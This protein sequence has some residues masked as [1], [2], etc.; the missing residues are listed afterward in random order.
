MN[1]K[2]TLRSLGL[3]FI[4]ISA[5]TI[6]YGQSDVPINS[7]GINTWF[8]HYYGP[9]GFPVNIWQTIS[10]SQPKLAR[11]GG[12]G[13]DNSPLNATDLQALV[14]EIRNN[15]GA[16]P[17]I[18]IPVGFVVTATPPYFRTVA[19]TAAQAAALVSAINGP[20]GTK[21]GRVNL[22]SIG[23]ESDKYFTGTTV[24]FAD[25][26]QFIR[27]F[28]VNFAVEMKKIDPNIKIFAPDFSWWNRDQPIMKLLIGDP[29]ATPTPLPATAGLTICEKALFYD[30]AF[31]AYPNIGLIDGIDFHNYPFPCYDPSCNALHPDATYDE[32]VNYPIGLNPGNYSPA[33]G[34]DV[35]VSDIKEFI[36]YAN[37]NASRTT[38]TNKLQWAVTEMNLEDKNPAIGNPGNASF[39]AGQ[40]WA[41][42]FA[43]ML[44][45]TS[46]KPGAS[47]IIPWTAKEGASSDHGY[48]D[49]TGNP[50]STFFHM[51]F[52][53][54][55]MKSGSGYTNQLY[56]AVIKGTATNFPNSTYPYI[57]TFG[58]K[59]VGKNQAAIMII[60][61]SKT[62][63]YTYEVGLNGVSSPWTT[64]NSPSIQFNMGLNKS[65][66]GTIG[67]ETTRLLVFDCSGNYEGMWEY[68]STDIAPKWIDNPGILSTIP[69]TILPDPSTISPIAGN[70]YNF[71]FSGAQNY[72]WF[73]IAGLTVN[74]PPKD[75]SDV[76]LL[77]NPGSTDY[78]FTM[79]DGMGCISTQLVR[80]NNTG[81]V[82]VTATGSNNYYPY[83]AIITNVRKACSGQNNGSITLQVFGAGTHNSIIT[84]SNGFTET[85]LN[86]TSTI[87]N[88]APGTY[89]VT[90]TT[91][92]E[93]TKSL[94]AIVETDIISIPIVNVSNICSST[95][96]T[97]NIF[98]SY[99]WLKNG[100]PLAGA[101]NY[102]LITNQL[103]SYQVAVTTVNGCVATSPSF[104]T[105]AGYTFPN[106]TAINSIVTF[107]SNETINNVLRIQNSGQLTINNTTVQFGSLGKIII[108][109]GGTL[110][111]NSSI[112]KYYQA[113]CSNWQGIDVQS[114]GTLNL[115]NSAVNINGPYKLLILAG[116]TLNY[117]QGSSVVLADNTS[118]MEIQGQLNI[119]ANANFTYSG[120]GFVRFNSPLATNNISA[121]TGSSMVFQ[122][123]NNNQ[124]AL[125]VNQAVLFIPS[126]IAL[127]KVNKCQVQLGSNAM[128]MPQGLN[129]NIVFTNSKLSGNA[130]SGGLIIFGQPNVTINNSIFDSGSY[131]I[132]A[133]LTYGGA[134]LTISNC[135]FQ[136]C[137]TGLLTHDKGVTLKSV[138][139]YDCNTGWVAEA[140]SF[141]CVSNN[142]I[143]GSKTR[144]NVVGIQYRGGANGTLFLNNSKVNGNYTDGIQMEG[145]ELKV[146][147]GEIKDNTDNGIYLS[148]NATLNMSNDLG[149]GNV[150]ATNNGAQNSGSY[151][152][153]MNNAKNIWL[154]N[155]FNDFTRGT[156]NF[157]CN[158][159][160][161]Q[162]PMIIY[163]TT[164]IEYDPCGNTDCSPITIT[165][166]RNKWVNLNGNVAP[167]N[168]EEYEI[169]TSYNCGL[170]GGGVPRNVLLTDA[171]P[172][173]LVKCDNNPKQQKSISLLENCPTCPTINTVNFP[174]KKLDKA[175]TSVIAIMDS[176]SPG[177][178]KKAEELFYEILKYPIPSPNKDTKTLLEISYQLMLESLGQAF[179]KSELISTANT[180]VLTSN[181]QQMVEI[182]DIRII[183]YICLEDYKQRLAASMDKAQAYRLAERRDI[184]L[185]TFDDILTW[186]EAPDQQYVQRWRC[187]TN[188]EHQLKQGIIQPQDFKA[189]IAA[190]GNVTNMRLAKSESE[191][192]VDIDLPK[193]MLALQP[194]P[195]SSKTT[196]LYQLPEGIITGNI[197]IKNTF[198]QSMEKYSI[199][200]KKESIELDCSSYNNGVYF[201]SLIS[202][203]KIITTK[204]LIIAK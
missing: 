14:D 92:G 157:Q 65:E 203:G 38:S 161:T 43:L 154:N 188:A 49:Q 195:A 59:V 83:Q 168:S 102:N 158:K 86:G 23:N 1:I 39:V 193:E 197:T 178:N 32:I 24:S 149:G 112:L 93:N 16:E 189:A 190:C 198:G 66:S 7:Y 57:K 106:G 133:L 76:S 47:F 91:L 155:G 135:T 60:N 21:P 116:G 25:Q 199:D 101:I 136:N 30:A 145:T 12:I 128:I 51:K 88:L 132:Y 94:T 150:D 165:A 159:Y 123:N 192:I 54:D 129:T 19:N 28:I 15:T 115:N 118:I 82:I 50:R 124:K 152:I 34:F 62:N 33:N 105:L 175:I 174:N 11:I 167:V 70:T 138:N 187:M 8:N 58:A 186:A 95:L 44:D 204:K 10:Q 139:F 35:V 75:G 200:D 42:M 63:S 142:S 36:T 196:V 184:A 22:W 121:G 110:T 201:I 148:N 17:I 194:N 103:G 169:Q 2:K 90:I 171:S 100:T 87:S 5:S 173:S 137:T 107:N 72:S 79:T 160:H 4:F 98:P 147:C 117:N 181:V 108:E 55:Y 182:Q 84:W 20:T 77:C 143:F 71:T 180:P 131:G 114:G 61:Q 170:Y 162:C 96:S 18:Q 45:G 73:P 37:T 109:S 122:C 74:I 27:D 3:G 177:N 9:G 127:F 120:N 78:P 81:P 176:T 80:V 48:L 56:K 46:A 99:Q 125:E 151:T 119:G 52:M 40:Y 89:F 31:T 67:T 185:T 163:G 113:C 26:A 164:N 144:P 153:L 126:N 69:I 41:E 104:N 134:P 156:V 85:I 130:N 53:A 202:D 29:F 172:S 97:S 64:S 141:P 68:N 6:V 179:L 191:R 13:L 183:K 146:K 166:N 140:M 111:I